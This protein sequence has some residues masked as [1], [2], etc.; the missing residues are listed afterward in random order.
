MATITQN[1]AN[2]KK[3]RKTMNENKI[4][5]SNINLDFEDWK[6]DLRSEYPNYSEDELISLMYDINND[7]LND[8]RINLNIQLSQPIIVIG[9][10]GL[11]YGR[12]HGYKM[13]K[14]G[15]IK[16]CLYSD[17]DYAEWYVDKLGNLRGKG[18]HHDA[19]NYYLYRVFKPNVSEIQIENFQE[20]LYHGTATRKDITRLTLRLGDAIG[21]IYGWEF[22]NRSKSKSIN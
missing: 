20:K 13:I 1:T 5:W 16:D 10:L 6:D 8:E 15:N 17:C 3:E 18:V 22:P 7:Y 12:A 4:I 9:D 11:W 19:T 14:S 2:S 21:K